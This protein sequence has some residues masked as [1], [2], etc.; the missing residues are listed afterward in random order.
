MYGYYTKHRKDTQ[1]Q[2][3]TKKM[4]RRIDRKKITA[5][6]KKMNILFFSIG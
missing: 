4:Y 3:Y 2:I 5:L 6:L 1:L